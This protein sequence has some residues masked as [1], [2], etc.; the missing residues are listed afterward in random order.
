MPKKIPIIGLLGGIGSGKSLVADQFR[1]LG[2]VVID[3]DRMARAMLDRPEIVRQLVQWWGAAILDPQG[4]PSRP[5]IARIVF[6][7]PKQRQRLEALIH[8]LV[9]AERAELIKQYQQMVEG[10]AVAIVDDTPLLMEVGL[11]K[12]CDVRVFV[13]VPQEV[14]LRRVME[15]RGWSAEELAKREKEQYPLDSKAQDADYV[16]DN[17][18]DESHCFDQVRRILSQLSSSDAAL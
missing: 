18:A 15:R 2:C 14:R 7:D 10:R 8:P 5:A 4:K 6:D 9:L 1:R 12:Q 3:A 16:V 13:R 11:D 17:D